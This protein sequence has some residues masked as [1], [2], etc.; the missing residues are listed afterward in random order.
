[1]HIHDFVPG[2]DD[3]GIAASM[4]Y[5]LKFVLPMLDKIGG[6]FGVVNFYGNWFLEK[7]TAF[8]DLSFAV[9]ALLKAGHTLVVLG[10]EVSCEEVAA[11]QAEALA[12]LRH[13]LSMQDTTNDDSTILTSLMLAATSIYL[14]DPASGAVHMIRVRQMLEHRGGIEELKVD[15]N[16]KAVCRHWQ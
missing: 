15:D 10:R 1:M 8:P 6:S 16:I 11:Y 13:R 3:P 9:M 14:K 7:M 5:H 4:D 12:H 2:G